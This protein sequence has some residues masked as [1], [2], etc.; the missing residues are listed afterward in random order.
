MTSFMQTPGGREI[1][2]H[3]VAHENGEASRGA[4]AAPSALDV[5]DASSNGVQDPA[6]ASGVELVSLSAHSMSVEPPSCKML[7]NALSCREV[8]VHPRQEA[9]ASG[10]SGEEFAQ[11]LLSAIGRS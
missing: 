5:L 4:K 11:I 7:G 1:S 9:H 10:Q 2:N 6:P 8:A 3:R